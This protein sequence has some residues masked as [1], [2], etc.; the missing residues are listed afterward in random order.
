M[1][2]YGQCRTC[3]R[4]FSVRPD[5]YFVRKHGARKRECLGSKQLA[6]GYDNPMYTPKG[7][8]TVGTV[9]GKA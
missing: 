7:Y 8:P 2:E 6:S 4:T 1:T 5:G 9:M 3:G